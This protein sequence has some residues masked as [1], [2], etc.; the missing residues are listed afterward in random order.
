[1]Y[2]NPLASLLLKPTDLVYVLASED[3]CNYHSLIIS[4]MNR[5]VNKQYYIK[6]SSFV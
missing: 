3:S 4:A 1:V 6:L 5:K 2:T